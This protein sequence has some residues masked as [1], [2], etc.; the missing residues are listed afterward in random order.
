MDTLGCELRESSDGKS[1]VGTILTEGRAAQD[2]PE[3]FAPGAAV[4]PADGI[5]ILA[6]HQG[7]TLATA[8]P[9]R[10]ASG[11]ITVTTP[12]TPELREAVK[13]KPFM[14]IEFRS[15]SERRTG[16]IREVMRGFIDA[17]ALVASPAYPQTSA[18]VR[19]ASHRK[20]IWA[21]LAGF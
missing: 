10:R 15:L 3:L 21:C 2:R 8:I 4:W 20:A 7:Q 9:E 6:D 18:E 16:S 11:E 1:F 17:A 5:R 19:G 13:A 14:S 12:A